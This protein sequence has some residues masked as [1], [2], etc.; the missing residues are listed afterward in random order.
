MN[1]S[2][3]FSGL[4]GIRAIAALSVVFSH[5]TISLN[6]FGLDSYLFGTYP[7]G[8]PIT[9]LLAGFGVSIFFSLSGFLITYLLLE[10]K[11]ESHINIKNFYLR[12][13]LRIWPLYYLYLIICLITL[14]LFNIPFES[15]T[16]LFYILL[17]ANVPFIIGRAIPFLSHFWSLG[18]EEQFYSFWPWIV[19]KSDSVLTITFIITLILILLKCLFK[20]LA[21][22]YNEMNF[23]YDILHVTRFHCMLIGA[24]GAILLFRQNRHF[25]TLMDNFFTQTIAWLIIILVAVNRFHLISFLDNEFI[26]VV[27]VFLIVGQLRLKYRIVNLDIPVFNFLGRISYGI[28]VFHP[29]VIFYLSQ[30]IFMDEKMGSGAYG[31]VYFLIFFLTILVA[32]VSFE[33]FEKRFLHLKERYSTIKSS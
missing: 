30:L 27:T 14:L 3:H 13:I 21:L 19:K 31:V 2:L 16:I 29:L 32:H 15:S 9:T 5:A 20:I 11:R 12:R 24:M 18:V 6:T 10:E 8:N 26:A 23:L 4:N 33:F 1:R 7:D 28:Y 25:I 22:R 17:S